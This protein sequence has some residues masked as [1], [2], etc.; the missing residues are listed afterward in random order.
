MTYENARPWDKAHLDK[1]REIKRNWNHRHPEQKK[2][3]NDK[4][5]ATPRF[6]S[7]SREHQALYRQK[8]RTEVLEMYGGKCAC[9]GEQEKDFLAIDHVDGNGAKGVLN[10][11]AGYGYSWYLYLR[12]N[13]PDHVRILCHNCNMARS[14]YGSCPH[15]RNSHA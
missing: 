3:I 11:S 5:V 13:K 7:W 1:I 6:K 15:E 8:I 12:R 9:R 14:F 2:A 4:Y 10:R